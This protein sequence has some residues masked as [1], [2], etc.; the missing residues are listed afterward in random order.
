MAS[1]VKAQDKG[2]WDQQWHD[3][4][5]KAVISADRVDEDNGRQC[6]IAFDVKVEAGAVDAGSGHDWR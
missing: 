3:L 2:P 1:Q 4:V 6:S 5:P